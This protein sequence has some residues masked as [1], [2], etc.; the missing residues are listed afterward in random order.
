METAIYRAEADLQQPVGIPADFADYG[1]DVFDLGLSRAELEDYVLR[2][3]L[4]I[5]TCRDR[6]GYNGDDHWNYWLFG[7]SDYLKVKQIA[8]DL[9]VDLDRASILDLGGAS[10]RVC[11]H[12]AANHPDATV[13][14]ADLNNNHIAWLKRHFGTK[15]IAFQNNSSHHLPL[16]DKSCDVIMAFSVFTHI[17]YHADMLLLELRRVLKKGGI[18]YI[19]FHSDVTWAEHRGTYLQD[20]LQAYEAYLPMFARPAAARLDQDVLVFRKS[21]NPYDCQVFQR[22]EYLVRTWGSWF[23]KTVIRHRF[24][25]IHSVAVFQK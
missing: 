4:P 24:H 20:L 15:V 5:P 22:S 25:N 7:L 17:D 9:S 1:R 13:M 23:S 21:N 11:R 6:E 18:A 8:K 2:D 12:M 14:L 10:G 16:E 3:R 19:T